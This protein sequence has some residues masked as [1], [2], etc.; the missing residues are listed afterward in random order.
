MRALI[1]DQKLCYEPDGNAGFEE[2]LAY[3]TDVFKA[4]DGTEQRFTVRPEC[5]ESLRFTLRLEEAEG[6]FIEQLVRT[7]D[8]SSWLVPWWP[9]AQKATADILTDAAS[10]AVATVGYCF[11]DYGWCLI[12]RRAAW[13]GSYSSFEG[14]EI[15]TVGSGVLNFYSGPGADW[16][17]ADGP[18]YLI[19]ARVCWLAGPPKITRV[20][21]GVRE[22]EVTFEE[23]G[24]LRT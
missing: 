19:P 20:V 13:P 23:Q 3:L 6:A 8:S 9:Y 12:W 18:M 11:E 1:P 7:N 14:V 15:T 17:L 2:T 24:W 5:V 4:F 21:K 22:M 10:A 16:L